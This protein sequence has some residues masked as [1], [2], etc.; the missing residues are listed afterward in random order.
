MIK[1][2][3]RVSAVLPAPEIYLSK[4]YFNFLFHVSPKLMHFFSLSSSGELSFEEEH[5]RVP[6]GRLRGAGEEARK[7]SVT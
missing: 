7:V 4:I 2:E 1:L 6:S 5:G 3:R